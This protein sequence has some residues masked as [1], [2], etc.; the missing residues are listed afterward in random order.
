MKQ[1][2]AE[3]AVAV[4][5]AAGAAVFVLAN[6]M[7]GTVYNWPQ[8]FG[9]VAGAIAFVITVMGV[10]GISRNI[11]DAYTLQVAAKQEVVMRLMREMESY[12][13]RIQNKNAV[14]CLRRI[15]KHSFDLIQ[16][17]RQSQPNNLLSAV[18]VL[19]NWL[20]VVC[21]LNEQYVDVEQHPEYQDNA[22]ARLAKANAALE[23]FD[24]FLLNSIK[25]IEKGDN[26]QFDV[27][28]NMLDSAKFNIA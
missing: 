23:S 17:T 4:A 1:M 22:D 28:T 21:D 16:R 13:T 5:L 3:H 26:V 20:K 11:V 15:D 10:Y 8:P 7:F 12:F 6:Y 18:T 2:I 19:E 27:A 24:L 25:A 9:A 14:D